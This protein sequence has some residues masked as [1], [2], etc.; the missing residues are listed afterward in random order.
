MVVFDV[1]LNNTKRKV[2]RSNTRCVHLIDW[3]GFRFAWGGGWSIFFDEIARQS[4]KVCCDRSNFLTSFCYFPLV[5]IFVIVF[6][7]NP[8]SMIWPLTKVAESKEWERTNAH[9]NFYLCLAH[10]H[11]VHLLN[12]F[13]WRSVSGVPY[14]NVAALIVAALVSAPKRVALCRRMW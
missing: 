1:W 9:L 13:G 4:W 5:F 8:L 6:I 7:A 14:D 3:M 12:G 2:L 10:N 11:N